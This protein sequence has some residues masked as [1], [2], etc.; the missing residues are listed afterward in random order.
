MNVVV[1]DDRYS[2]YERLKA[3]IGSVRQGLNQLKK[4]VSRMISINEDAVF[5][6]KD[7]PYLWDK[8]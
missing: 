4:I 6:S 3:I 7:W 5:T 2:N 8:R 1:L